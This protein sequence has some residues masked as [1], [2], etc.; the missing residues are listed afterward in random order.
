MPVQHI[1]T[2]QSNPIQSNLIL[3][4]P[5]FKLIVLWFS[6]KFCQVLL[7]I[8]LKNVFFTKD[9]LCSEFLLSLVIGCKSNIC[10]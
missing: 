1:Q 3:G 4:Y 10:M 2:I 7:L 6:L 5:S 9:G 8:K